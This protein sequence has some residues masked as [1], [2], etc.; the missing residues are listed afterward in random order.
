MASKSVDFFLLIATYLVTMISCLVLQLT[1]RNAESSADDNE[2]NKQVIEQE[3]QSCHA[4]GES[5][6]RSIPSPE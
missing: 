6:E 3:K 1:K 2:E 5:N 4:A